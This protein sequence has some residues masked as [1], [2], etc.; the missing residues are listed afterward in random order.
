GFE[1]MDKIRISLT[2]NEKL[3]GIM[4]GAEQQI[5]SEVMAVEA[6]YD[7][8]VGYSKEWSINGETATLGVEKVQA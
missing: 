2:G 6:V 7:A 5:L 1:V 8:A 3:T 4:Q